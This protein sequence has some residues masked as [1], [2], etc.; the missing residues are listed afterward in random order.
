LPSQSSFI[1][2]QQLLGYNISEQKASQLLGVDADTIRALQ[3]SKV[4]TE[5]LRRR[6]MG[7]TTADK[8]NSHKALVRLGHDPSK[9]KVKKTLGIDDQEVKQV[10]KEQRKQVKFQLM[11]K[12]ALSCPT[13]DKKHAMKALQTLGLDISTNKMSK[14]L[15][16]EE[17]EVRDACNEEISKQEE[18]IT[19]KRTNSATLNKKQIQKALNVI[20]Y[21]PSLEKVMDTLG[22]DQGTAEEQE[23]RTAI[24]NSNKDVHLVGKYTRRFKRSTY[25]TIG[26]S[27]A[28]FLFVALSTMAATLNSRQAFF[29]L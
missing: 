29:G 4:E 21:N 7:I 10:E 15:G 16:L 26:L 27:I 2:L 1:K 14:I 13:Q 3:T 8:R 18:K 12:R 23:I 19:R 28:A 9:E 24:P 6:Q 25:F 5:C 11:R 22:V 17:E 20:G